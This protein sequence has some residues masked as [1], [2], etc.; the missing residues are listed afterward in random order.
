MCNVGIVKK[1]QFG[2]QVDSSRLEMLGLTLVIRGHENAKC[3]SKLIHNPLVKVIVHLEDLNYFLVM[4][5]RSSEYV[6]VLM[7]NVVQKLRSMVSQ[8]LHISVVGS[9]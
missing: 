8:K 6:Q 3:I 2:N 7:G 4:A 5:T 1:G 9:S